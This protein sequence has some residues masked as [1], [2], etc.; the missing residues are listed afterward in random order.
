MKAQ[1]SEVIGVKHRRLR[2]GRCAEEDPVP[3]GRHAVASQRA[4]ERRSKQMRKVKLLLVAVALSVPTMIAVPPASAC[5]GPP[6]DQINE[7]CK[8][9]GK[10]QCLG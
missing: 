6:C 9:V 5:L 7:V 1:D 8:R 4:S 10:G 3:G 2:E